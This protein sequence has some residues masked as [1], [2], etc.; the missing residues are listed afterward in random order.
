MVSACTTCK[1]L[2]K[3]KQMESLT[4][5]S[6][7]STEWMNTNL[8]KLRGS[9]GGGC[10]A[11]SLLLQGILLHHDKFAASREEDVKVRAQTYQSPDPTQNHLSV[12]LH[13]KP[14][15]SDDSGLED[16]DE[17][18]EVGLPDLKLEYYTEEGMRPFPCIMSFA[19]SRLI[20]VDGQSPFSAIG[21]GRRISNHPL[22]DGGLASAGHWIRQCLS[23]H[24]RCNSSSS[25]TLPT[26]IL[27]V[28]GS[29]GA[30]Q[31]HESTA[32]DEGEML[33]SGRYIALSHCYGTSQQVPLTTLATLQ[34]HKQAILLANLPKMYQEAVI[35]TRALGLRWLWIDSLCIIADSR[36]DKM[37]QTS[38][39]D[40]IFGNAFLT[41]AAT[42]AADASH[43]LFASHP[44]TFK[45][46]AMNNNG[47]VARVYVREQ[48]SHY[49]FKGSFDEDS[50]MIDWEVPF[51]ISEEATAQAPLLKRTWPYVER[52]LSPRVLHFTRSEMIL[53]CREG[54]QCECGRIDD[55]ALDSRPTDTVKREYAR[56]T[57]SVVEDSNT[58]P[59]SPITQQK[60]TMAQRNEALQLW[61]YIITEY[62]SRDMTHDT[63]RLL[64]IA[65][66]AKTFLPVIQSGYIAGHWTFS[67]LNLLWYPEDTAKCRRTPPA[68][69]PSWSWAAVAGS[70][71]LFDNATA[72]DLA[73]TAS[74]D[75]ER[76]GQP[77]WTP[78]ARDSFGVRLSAAMA[79]EV[80]FHTHTNSKSATTSFCLSKNNISVAF[81]PDFR[82]ADGT[83]P[84]SDSE[85]LTC[86]WF[87]MSFRS[88]IIG[89][90][91]QKAPEGGVYQRVGRF[92]CY[93]CRR[94]GGSG[95]QPAEDAEALFGY[96]FPKVS[97][98][99]RVD[100]LDRMEFV[101]V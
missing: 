78:F 11:C 69:F 73:C 94:V 77:A 97:N 31:L 1:R 65:S 43:G 98:L 46:Q 80:T 70:P 52:L 81:E 82:N 33:E 60:H 29:H 47:Q 9:S 96:W 83:A 2:Q 55:A 7:M 61:S 87:S 25:S 53:E 16:E 88:S 93:E 86:V 13:W 71:I 64:A 41:I 27:D 90:V 56:I 59:L 36:D 17:D 6:E 101:V 14:P 37:K 20:F 89:L 4:H 48:P 30:I 51:N 19:G 62:T 92:E 42:S 54:L 34:T 26:R 91:L 44:E 66:I 72:M 85:T 58:A 40:Q 22:Q 75:A 35:L 100:E 95:G 38:V 24:K 39:M 28:S 10:R 84:I 74:F 21:C 63:D 49:S 23:E 45:I 32:K 50:H 8:A 68:E 57:S 3:F 15:N 67:T 79:T 12:E 99:M 76:D 5:S 18:D